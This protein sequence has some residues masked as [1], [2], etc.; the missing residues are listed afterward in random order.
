VFRQP[1]VASSSPCLA[2]H[3]R[4]QERRVPKMWELVLCADE[5][6]SSA[7]SLRGALCWLFPFGTASATYSLAVQ[8]GRSHS[9][10]GRTQLPRQPGP[11]AWDGGLVR[12]VEL[13]GE[14]PGLGAAGEL[15]CIAGAVR[16]AQGNGN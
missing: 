7:D 4:P 9:D 5:T 12:G 6:V 13:L 1:R 15:G 10:L 11:R 3:F 2:W 16:L 8:Q 14:V